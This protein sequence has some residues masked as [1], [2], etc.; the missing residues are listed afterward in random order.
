M[1]NLIA[2]AA[3]V[4]ANERLKGIITHTPLQLN[5]NLS[6]SYQAKIYLKREDLQIV[7]SY[8]LRGAFN[9]IAQL[10]AEELQNGVVCAS[11]GN[12]A[13]GFA[14]ACRQL[15][16]QGTIF[17]PTPTPD[18]KIKQVRMFGKDNVK[19]ILAGDTFDDA[20]AE[21]MVFQQEKKA[22][23]IHPFDDF[24]VICGQGTVG[25]EIIAD[26]PHTIDY[27]FVPIGGGGLSA[28]V[29]SYFKQISPQTKII[30][31]EPEGAPAMKKSLENSKIMILDEI[32]K[33][34]D[35]A[36]VKK[37]GELNFKICQTILDKVI[38]VPEGKV[39]TT[40]LKLYNEDAIVV[41]PAG[42]LAIAALDYFKDEIKGK[43]VVAIVSG[44][45]NDI[46]R[47]EEI[48]ER[49]LFHERL[50]HYFII[51]FPQR[52]GALKEFVV[53]VL[54]ETDDITYF[55]YT[56]K[57][58]REKGPALVGIQLQKPND[59]EILIEKLNTTGFSYEMLNE[60]PELYRF[61]F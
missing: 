40:I 22:V 21:A 9:K 28:G 53:N 57:N 52:A 39:C 35:G 43:N 5:L 54:G 7:R 16:I 45:N 30:G 44:G 36:A 24:D 27:L 6:E 10:K 15:N 48:K 26:C 38:T 42:A 4:Q 33:F 31:I 19:V 13:Q 25:L 32:D 8:K 60:Q 55:E 47:M 20:F 23:F 3:I 17:M 2:V 51:N 1:N 46:T 59:F 37:V 11:A 56:K 41:E 18:Q 29:G 61:L 34:V 50:K 49:S 14:Y 12:H 58:N